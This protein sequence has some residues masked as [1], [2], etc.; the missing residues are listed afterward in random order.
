MKK[1]ISTMAWRWTISLPSWKPVSN[2]GVPNLSTAQWPINW[3]L[4][5]DLVFQDDFPKHGLNWIQSRQRPL[6]PFA[7]FSPFSYLII[8]MLFKR[9][10]FLPVGSRCWYRPLHL[11]AFP[12]LSCWWVLEDS[13]EYSIIWEKLVPSFFLCRCI[14]PWLSHLT[15]SCPP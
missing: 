15:P 2:P 11:T 8:Q 13:Y 10:H 4:P 1:K 3:L 14:I 6:F 9:I 7:V 5:R 12:T